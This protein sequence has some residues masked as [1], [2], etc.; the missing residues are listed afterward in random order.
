MDL[1]EQYVLDLVKINPT[2]NDFTKI[3]ELEHLKSK[4]VD[5]FKDSYSIKESK[6][7]ILLKQLF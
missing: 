6:L 1:S 4:P 2:L 3:D 5:T 7:I